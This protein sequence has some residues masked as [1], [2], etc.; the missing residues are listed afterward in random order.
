M[1]TEKRIYRVPA[2]E[3]QY[4]RYTLESYDGMAVV[5]T[6]DP[7][8]A[9]IEITAAPG[10]GEIVSEIIDSLRRDEGIHVLEEESSR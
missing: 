1:R 7:G 5:K 8:P 10:C 6:L 9:L 4:V 3:I 2:R